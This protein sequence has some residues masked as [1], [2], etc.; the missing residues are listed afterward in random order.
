[1]QIITDD[2]FNLNQSLSDEREFR[3]YLEKLR[4]EFEVFLS[5]KLSKRTIYKH[6]VIIGLLIDF[7]CFD[8]GLRSLDDLTVGMVNSQFRRWHISK[9]GDAQESEIKTAVKK[10]FMFLEQEKGF[11]NKKIMDSFKK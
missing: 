2:E 6:S 4:K 9:I 1:M 10:F 8:C 7:L 3:A 11:S 5:D